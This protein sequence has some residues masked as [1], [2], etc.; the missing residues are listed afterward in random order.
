MT[1]L[2]T[3]LVSWLTDF[4]RDAVEDEEPAPPRRTHSSAAARTDAT[5]R[6]TRQITQRDC[7]I[8][9]LSML[10]NVPY[11][12]ARG[13]LFAPGERCTGT[14]GVRM[15]R[16]L[17]ELGI[18]HG[19][20]FVRFKSWEDIPSDALVHIKWRELPPEAQGHW[21]VFQKDGSRLRVID[22]ASWDE[23]LTTA[24]TSTMKGV[25]YC[26]VDV[27]RRRSASTTEQEEALPRT[28]VGTA[29]AARK[30]PQRG[31]RATRAPR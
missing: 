4:G 9:A 11:R 18:A 23:T 12:T 16:A 6:R 10:A 3:R 19:G 2:W 22:P 21:V 20:R 28:R 13:L 17:T 26:T 24:D 8:A 15:R 30:K 5:V 7:G 14:T 29:S 31:T 25:S 1:T 27:V